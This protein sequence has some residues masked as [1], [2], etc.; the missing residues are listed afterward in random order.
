ME[1]SQ[2]ASL[3]PKRESIGNKLVANSSKNCIYFSMNDKIH[4][5]YFDNGPDKNVPDTPRKISK[6]R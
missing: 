3:S 1:I 2:E 6:Q 4:A 5:K